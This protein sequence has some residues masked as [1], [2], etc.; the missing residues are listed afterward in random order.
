M[1][2]VLVVFL[3]AAFLMQMNLVDVLFMVALTFERKLNE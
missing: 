1:Y 2:T 3:I